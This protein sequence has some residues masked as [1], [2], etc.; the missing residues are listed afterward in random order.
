[1]YYYY[2]YY[3]LCL[4]YNFTLTMF[5]YVYNKTYMVYFVCVFPP[6]S[7]LFFVRTNRVTRPPLGKT[8]L[9]VLPLEELLLWFFVLSAVLITKIGFSSR[10]KRYLLMRFR[11]FVC[12]VLTASN[13]KNDGAS[14]E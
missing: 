6:L 4:R 11:W 14:Q 2:Y 8:A 10:P 1:M 5:S 7:R 9:V 13:A 12:T 3:Y